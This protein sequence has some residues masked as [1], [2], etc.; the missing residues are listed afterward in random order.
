MDEVSFEENGKVGKGWGRG[1]SRPPLDF[2]W[3]PSKFHRVRIETLATDVDSVCN[4]NGFLPDWNHVLDL[5]NAVKAKPVAGGQRLR[6]SARLA[7][8]IEVRENRV[9]NKTTVESGF[10]NRLD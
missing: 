2:G 10:R 3:K 9:G 8:A 4:Q 5:G 6:R 1:L 7:C